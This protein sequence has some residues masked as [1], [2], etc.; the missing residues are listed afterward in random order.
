MSTFALRVRPRVER[1]RLFAL[2]QPRLFA[3]TPHEYP[4]RPT[5][6]RS[7]ARPLGPCVAFT[8]IELLVVIA[9]IAILAALLLPALSAA[10]EKARQTRCFN[11][12][13][14]VILACLLYADAEN[15]LPCGWMTASGQNAKGY[16]TYDEL[17]LPHGA[18]TNVLVCPSHRGGTRHFWV[19]GNVLPYIPPAP[20]QTGVIGRNTAV[21]PDAIQRP[22][23]TVALTEVADWVTTG[24][25]GYGPSAPG[26]EWGSIIQME[27][28]VIGPSAGIGYIHRRRDNILFC[29]GHVEA[30]TSNVLTQANLEKFYRDKTQVPKP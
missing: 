18:P 20:R 26:A 21:K 16:L 8:L 23:D 24:F 12:S 29:D 1:P 19:N 7:P 4:I 11:N 30:L 25:A 2:R 5:G 6:N 17:I 13:R 15:R 10:K 28:N 27:G 3:A 14:Q 22:A 9:I